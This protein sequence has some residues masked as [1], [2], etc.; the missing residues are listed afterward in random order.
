[1]DGRTA[2]SECLTTKEAADY[3]G[4]SQGWLTNL[5]DDEDGPA[6]RVQEQRIIYTRGDLDDWAFSRLLVPTRK[7]GRG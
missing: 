2:P 7:E 5:R 3:L 6:F 1:M 4:V